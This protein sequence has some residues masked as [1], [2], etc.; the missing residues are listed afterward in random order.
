MEGGD[1]MGS[2]DVYRAGDT[3]ICSDAAGM[4]VIV[5]NC[6]PYVHLVVRQEGQGDDEIIGGVHLPRE[7]VVRLVA[8][9]DHYSDAVDEYA[10]RHTEE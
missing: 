8:A 6:H 5:G 4:M 7:A 3:P 1:E 10:D 9:I 2:I